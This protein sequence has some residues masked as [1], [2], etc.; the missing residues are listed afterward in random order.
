MFLKKA[1]ASILLVALL[2]GS[3]VS[4]AQASEDTLD[5]E[6]AAIET[7]ENSQILKTNNLRIEQ[8]EKN[9][10]SVKGQLNQMIGLLPYMPN[11]F[12][13]VQ[14]Y[15]LTPKM[16]E[17]YLTQF[18]GGQAVLTNAVRLS[19]YSSYIELLKGDYEVNAQNDLMNSLYEDY[20]KARL[21]EE[22]GMVTASQLRLAEIA[23]EQIRYHYLSAQNSK[24]SALMALNN[25]M[26]G[27]ISRKYS[28][29][30]DYNV[31]PAPQIRTLEEYTNQALANR[32]E[33]ISAQS[34]LDLLEEQ[35]LY[36]LA[37]IPS[38]Y[39][40]Y[41]Q[42]QEYEIA[43]ARNTLDLARINVRQN[44]AELYAGLESS[45]KALEAMQYLAEQAEKN[46]QTAQIRYDQSEITFVELNNAKIAKVQAE[47]D[48]KKA[49]LDAWLMQTTMNLACDAGVQP[50]GY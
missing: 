14:S 21:Q 12:E 7:I 22:K 15:V 40:F 1:L 23:Y 29:L 27:D 36:G 11:P 19:A 47:I 24:D 37:S 9:Y 39:E 3:T 41:K 44:I 20:K 46:I 10:S 26:G 32:A 4:A 30:Q 48:L 5:I 8:M 50:T 13:L 49:E 31:T 28:V 2:L 34:A 17:D 18:Y 35:Y 45:M 6:K 42:Q 33:I 38:D 25:M 16:Y 43:N